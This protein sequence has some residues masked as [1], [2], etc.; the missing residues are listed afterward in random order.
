MLVNW[1][2]GI[3]TK[4]SSQGVSRKIVAAGT[5]ASLMGA[6]VFPSGALATGYGCNIARGGYTCFTA[7]GEGTHIWG[8]SM[9]RTKYTP[10]VATCLIRGKHRT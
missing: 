6:L 2:E 8:V 3:T 9:D 5:I 7:Y 4:I 10:V 1:F